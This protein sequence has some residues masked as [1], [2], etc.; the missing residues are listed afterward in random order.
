MFV[1]HNDWDTCL[2]DQLTMDYF[3]QLELFLQTESAQATIYPARSDWFAAFQ[4][5]SYHD[6]KVVILGQDPYHHPEQAHGLAFS[7]QRGVKLPPSLRNIFQELQD[8]LQIPT[9]TEGDLRGWAKQGVL[10]LNTVLTVREYEPLSHRN[11]GWEKFTDAVISKLNEREQPIVFVLWG[12][13]ASSKK[14]LINQ[15]RHAIIEAPHPSPLSAYRGFF[16][17]RPFTQVN[18][19]LVRFGYKEIDWSDLDGKI[20]TT[21]H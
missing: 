21:D 7:V 8:N 3:R 20:S 12:K 13:P 4:L 6:V 16:G 5:T 11:R 1:A 19:H 9:P 14:T 15:E 17:S 2:K 18:A 10:L